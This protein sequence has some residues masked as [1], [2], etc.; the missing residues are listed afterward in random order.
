MIGLTTRQA[1]ALRF[2]S[3]FQ[4]AHGYSPSLDEIG[5]ALGTS[6]S[7]SF[8]LVEALCEREALKKL[9]NRDRAIEVLCALPVPRCPEGEPLYFVPVGEAAI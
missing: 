4:T 8:K 1:D 6:K 7:S 5:K 9:P 2:I 3:G